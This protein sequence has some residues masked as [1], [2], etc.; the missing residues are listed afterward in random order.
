ME[1][2][3]DWFGLVCFLLMVIIVAGFGTLATILD[4]ILMLF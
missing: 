1:E 3:G 2:L 4:L